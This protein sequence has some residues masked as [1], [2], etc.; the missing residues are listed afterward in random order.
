MEKNMSRVQLANMTD[1]ELLRYTYMEEENP[2]VQELCARIAR[3]IDENAELKAQLN[4][5][6]H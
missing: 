1:E 4:N 3:L 5:Q 6:I 2:L